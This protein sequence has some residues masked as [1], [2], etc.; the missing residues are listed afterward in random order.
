MDIII[1]RVGNIRFTENYALVNWHE[2]FLYFVI[3]HPNYI[4]LNMYSRV[5]ENRIKQFSGQKGQFLL[6]FEQI[7][8]E[9]L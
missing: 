4:M 6:R 8:F 7:V 9:L 2:K 3:F 5:F 1:Y